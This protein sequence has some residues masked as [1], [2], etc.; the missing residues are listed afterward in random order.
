[1][2]T[3]RLSELR[4]IVT[5]I[6]ADI[7]LDASGLMQGELDALGQRLQ[8]CKEAITTLANVAEA[9]DNERKAIDEN[10]QQTKVYLNS[11]QKVSCNDFQRTPYKSTSCIYMSPMYNTTLHMICL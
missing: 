7:G 4:D 10:V 8:D 6:A 5:K 2:Q 1:M 3:D 9:K 11:I